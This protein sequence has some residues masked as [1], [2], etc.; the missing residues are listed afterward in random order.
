M[1]G[2][3]TGSPGRNL[4]KC[5]REVKDALP[6]QWCNGCVW[7]YGLVTLDAAFAEDGHRPKT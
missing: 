6:M 7:C 3:W 1:S 4:E 2:S 5:L